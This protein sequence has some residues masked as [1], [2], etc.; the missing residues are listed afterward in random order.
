MINAKEI[1]LDNGLDL[2]SYL[3]L[4]KNRSE[5][6]KYLAP[7]SIVI[8]FDDVAKNIGDI[9][10]NGYVMLDCLSNKVRKLT[11]NDNTVMSIDE[12][13]SSITLPNHYCYRFLFRFHLTGIIPH[14]SDLDSFYL[15]GS[16]LN[17]SNGSV[18]TG[19]GKDLIRFPKYLNPSTQYTVEKNLLYMLYNVPNSLVNVKP[20]IYFMPNITYSITRIAL[21]ITAFPLFNN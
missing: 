2:A 9:T 6:S 16:M 1:I 20:A 5:L 21:E 12:E 17:S 15:Y 14:D 13:S 7:E 4:V 11:N 8:S 10:E 19:S 18:V 3:E